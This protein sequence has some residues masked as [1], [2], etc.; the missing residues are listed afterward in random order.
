MEKLNL[1]L[2]F[3]IEDDEFQE[4]YNGIRNNWQIKKELSC[5]PIYNK[6]FLKMKIRS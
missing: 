2:N 1:N 5:E 6:K 4:K 3:L